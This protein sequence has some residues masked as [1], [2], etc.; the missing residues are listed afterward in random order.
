MNNGFNQSTF[1]KRLYIKTLFGKRNSLFSK[2][3]S[4]ICKNSILNSPNFFRGKPSF[5][6]SAYKV[7]GKKDVETYAE[8]PSQISNMLSENS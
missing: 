1:L 4:N 2:V 7:P 6:K 5:P 3:S 8:Q